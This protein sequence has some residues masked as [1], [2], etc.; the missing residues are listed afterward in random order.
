MVGFFSIKV[1]KMIRNFFSPT[2]R[3]NPADKKKIVSVGLFLSVGKISK[4]NH[5]EN[6]KIITQRM[7]KKLYLWGC[8]YGSVKKI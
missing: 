5:N 3:N 1:K 4:E 8:I 2:D 6:I 7:E